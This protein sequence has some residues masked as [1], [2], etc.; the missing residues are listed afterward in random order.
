M[1]QSDVKK[2][3]SLFIVATP[4]G[5]LE[6]ITLRAIRTLKEAD[7]IAAEDTRHTKKLLNAYDIKTPLT[8]LHGHNEKEKSAFIINKLKEG[9]NI[10]YVT[11]AGTPCIS[12]PGY[13]LISQAHDAGIRIVPVPGAA[14]VIAALSV[15]GFPADNFIFCG[16]LPTR[17]T[18]RKKHLEM[19]KSEDRVMVFYESPGRLLEMLQDLLDILGDRELVLAREITKAFEEIA[20]GKISDFIKQRNNDKIKGEVTLIINPRKVVENN[21]IEED[22]RRQIKQAR[23]DK[24]LSLRDAVQVVSQETGI[25]RKKVYAL[26]I[27]LKR[28]KKCGD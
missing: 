21:F 13:F 3:G 20:R 24:N 28:N 23:E 18:K 12:D 4:I 25:P 8:S 5:N 19:L 2:S 17:R 7:L 11:D 15:C 14:A 22:I 27:E 10:A 6:D 26:G 16:F 9:E 1:T